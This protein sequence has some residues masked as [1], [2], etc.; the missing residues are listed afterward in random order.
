MVYLVTNLPK[1]LSR[2]V[3]KYPLYMD[4][5][6]RKSNGWIPKMVGWNLGNS[7]FKHGVIS[8]VAINVRF[9]GLLTHNFAL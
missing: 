5:T 6:P 9:Q 1:N 7:G 4:T 2:K 3:G 8:R